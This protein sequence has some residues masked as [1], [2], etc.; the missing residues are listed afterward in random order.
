MSI[1]QDLK[2]MVLLSL[3]ALSCFSNNLFAQ[4]ERPNVLL[5]LVDDLKPTLGIYGDEVAHSPNI[6]R[7]ADQGNDIQKCLLQPGSLYGFT[8]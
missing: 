5:L 1:I 8:L 2:K 6:D 7:L 3:M 4:N